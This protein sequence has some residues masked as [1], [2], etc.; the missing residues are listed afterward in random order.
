[1]TSFIFNSCSGR[2]V[3]KA[4]RRLRHRSKLLLAKSWRPNPGGFETR[5]A[6]YQV[7]SPSHGRTLYLVPRE[8]FE[9]PTCGIEAHCSNPLSSRGASES[10]LGFRKRASLAYCQPRV[11]SSSSVLQNLLKRDFTKL[12]SCTS[13]W[14]P[15]GKIYL[16]VG[17]RRNRAKSH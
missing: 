13:L 14:G 16:F 8:G 6:S 12:Y 5:F 3:A 15:C 9:P 11:A 17:K 10:T 4:T 2:M 1:M 7:K